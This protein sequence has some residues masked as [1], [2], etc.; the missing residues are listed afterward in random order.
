MFIQQNPT[1]FWGL[2]ASMYIG[3]VMLLVLNLPMVGVFVRMLKVPAWFLMPAVVAISFVAVYSVNNSSFDILLM[4]GFGI[5]GFFLRQTGFPLASVILGL[6]LG[7]LVENNLRR[8]M[9]ISDGD[10]TYLFASPISITLWIL[11]VVSLFLPYFLS[12]LTPPDD[13]E[14][15][16]EWT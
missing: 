7:P 15:T 11:A 12:K 2:I 13:D 8:A 9:S 1:I 6:V 16:P 5:I 14:T 3:N 4:A 10:W